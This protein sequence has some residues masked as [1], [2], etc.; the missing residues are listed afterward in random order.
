MS[1]PD[2]EGRC[3]RC[4]SSPRLLWKGGRGEH[5]CAGCTASKARRAVAG[6]T[7]WDKAE[8]ALLW[9]KRNLFQR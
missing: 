6:T 8:D 2:K 4:G 1:D 7:S 3:D 5:L 9:V